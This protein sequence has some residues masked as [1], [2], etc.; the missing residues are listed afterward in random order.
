M[1]RTNVVSFVST[2]SAAFPRSMQLGYAILRQSTMDVSALST[3]VSG[4]STR[5]QGVSLGTTFTASTSNIYSN[6]ATL[7]SNAGNGWRSLSNNP[8]L[9]VIV[10]VT[11]TAPANTGLATLQSASASNNIIPIFIADGSVV[12][13]YQSVSLPFFNASTQVFPRFA[14]AAQSAITWAAATSAITPVGTLDAQFASVLPAV[15]PVAGFQ[16]V[17]LVLSYPRPAPANYVSPTT[18]T[19]VVW[20]YGLAYVRMHANLPPTLTGASV[21]ADEDTNTQ[22]SLST[23]FS[24]SQN[25]RLQFRFTSLPA[26]NVASITLNNNAVG[27]NTWYPATNTFNVLGAANYNGAF[28]VNV[29]VSDGC[30]NTTGAIPFTIRP[31]NDPPTAQSFGVTMLED[32]PTLSKRTINFNSSIADIDSP[33][34]IVYISSLPTNGQLMFGSTFATAVTRNTPIPANAVRFNPDPNWNGVTSFMYYVQDSSGA[35]SQ[36]A[37]VT[38][39]VTP[40]ND[41]PTSNDITLTTYEDTMLTIDQITGSDVEGDELTLIITQYVTSGSLKLNSGNLGNLPA[42]VTDTLLYTPPADQSGSPFT[43]FKFQFSDGTDLSPIYT[44]TINVLP[45]N[46]PPTGTDF[47]VNTNED[48]PLTISFINP[49]R[50]SDIDTA[51]AS[52]TVTIRSIGSSS[53]G[54][55]RQTSASATNLAQGT[56]LTQQSVYFIPQPDQNGAFTFTYDVSDGQARSPLYTATVNVIPINDAPT[57]STSNNVVLTDRQVPAVFSLYIRDV[58]DGDSLTARATSLSVQAADGAVAVVTPSVSV[59]SGAVTVLN[60]YSNNDGATKQL[61][62]QW[63]PSTTAPNTLNG[64]V[65]FQ[66]TDNSGATSNVVTVFLRVSANKNPT[67]NTVP[68]IVTDEDV[69]FLNYKIEAQDG[70]AGQ[71]TTLTAYIARLPDF[72]TLVSNGLDYTTA[73]VALGARQTTSSTTFYRLNYRPN[74]NYNGPDSFTFYFVDVLGGSSAVQTVDITVNPVNDQPI[75]NG[76]SVTTKEDTMVTITQFTV[77]DVDVGDT[78]KLV[79]TALPA[80]GTLRHP[81]GD[82]SAIAVNEEISYSDAASWELRYTPP[83]NANGSPFTTFKFRV[84]DSSGA[85]NDLSAE[86]IVTINVLPV[87]D[88]PVANDISLTTN[89]DTATTFHF[90][91][92]VSDVDNTD[93][94][95]TV[96]IT[97]LPTNG[98][99][100]ITTDGSTYTT[101]TQSQSF[102]VNSFNTRYIPATNFNGD[103]SF[104]WFVQDPSGATSAATASIT[105]NPV[106]DA[107]SSQDKSVT[108]IRDVPVDITNF[109]VTDVDNDDSEIDLIIVTLPVVGTLSDG[110]DLTAND[111]PFNAGNNPSSQVLKWTPPDLSG[112]LVNP[113]IPITTF[114]FKLNDGTDDSPVYTVSVYISYTNT[115]PR[116][117][118]SVTYIDEDTVGTIKI[119]AVDLET[120][121]S[122]LSVKIVSIAPSS[123]GTF[124]TDEALTQEAQIGAFLPNNSKAL[125]YVPPPNANSANGLPLATFTF[126]IRDGEDGYSPVYDGLVYVN[127]VNDPAVYNGESTLQAKEDEVLNINVGSQLTD[128]DSPGDIDL[129]IV[130]TVARGQL[131]VCAE[132]SN[133]CQQVAVNNGD[134]L[135]GTQ[136]QLKFLAAANENGANYTTFSFQALDSDGLYSATYVITIDVLPVNDPPVLVPHYNILPDRVVMYEDSSLVLEWDATDIDN[137][138]STLVARLTSAVPDNAKLYECDVTDGAYC[139]QGK[140]L[141]P[142]VELNSPFRNGT[143]RVLFVPDEN[144]FDDRNFATFSVVVTDGEDESN[145]ARSII[146]VR[147][148]NDAPVI[149]AASTDFV[150]NAD[151]T[152]FSRTPLASFVISDIDANR[153]PIELTITSEADT[154]F[155]EFGSQLNDVPCVIEP[156]RIMCLAPQADLREIYMAN[157]FF[158]SNITSQTTLNITVND[159]G[160]TDY[161]NRPLNTTVIVRI[162]YKSDT[163]LI[164]EQTTDNT[165]TIALSVSAGA[166]AAAVAITIWQVKKRN[167]AVDDYFDNITS[168]N[169]TA[170]TSAIYAGRFQ[171]GTNPFY[172]VNT[173][174]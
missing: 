90:S 168:M 121:E 102:A 41:P 16:T 64:T 150:S 137:D 148:V 54:V 21:G 164:D 33:T 38:I 144:A 36:S 170:S 1:L 2:I 89:E 46:D 83:A 132:G 108:T 28:S 34:P 131:Y 162:L 82:N 72:G 101:V 30:E 166:V 7:M 40:V 142:P 158:V 65:T 119:L 136:R 163:G 53:L 116:S 22:F 29:L 141:A 114:T 79:I 157:L 143:W 69:T 96:T 133:P 14:T 32:E 149:E 61:D 35:N 107:P 6:V 103:D 160:N 125:Y 10:V 94:Q 169:T 104:N 67:V 134:K 76:F 115:K 128:I 60:T 31:V 5:L 127:P 95:L 20:G 105:V 161:E 37:T 42:S 25:N 156:N 15:T 56:Q 106:N 171:E 122:G 70:D 151:T 19:Y 113:N 18:L 154:G 123:V 167:A 73:G 117:E 11:K 62:I 74:P 111:L 155:F 84:R 159:L 124:Y 3:D 130:K 81:A 91:D 50:I 63:T 98:R 129:Y 93:D 100:E 59:T 152:G 172:E 147:P 8:G 9:S 174:K 52:L 77:S 44:A 68:D 23:A 51:T 92:Y 173:G 118:P 24:D 66:V 126:Q 12:T 88:A 99:L 39:T 165:L 55:L 112:V 109:L 49:A 17:N 97:S 145:T 153:K 139:N 58:D 27:L 120:P 71:S 86:Q 4:T 78:F 138:V 146:R 80:L 47:T 135:S 110:D 85:A 43:T 45:V 75:T 13:T 57:L 140:E 87:N 26:A 48:T